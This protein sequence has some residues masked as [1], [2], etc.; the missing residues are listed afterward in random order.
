M[1]GRMEH[2]ACRRELRKYVKFPCL[3]IGIGGGFFW[4]KKV[5]EG[6]VGV[7]IRPKLPRTIKCDVLEGLPFEDAS[8]NCVV[9]TEIFEHIEPRKR[10]FLVCEI[11]RVLKE[12]GRIIISVPKRHRV[13]FRAKPKPTRDSQPYPHVL[14]PE[15]LF[16]DEE[17]LDFVELFGGN[18]K[19]FRISNKFYE[20]FGAVIFL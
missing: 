3:D 11:L 15:W 16:D 10:R 19:V 2:I 5:P 7:D 14:Y 4:D 12:R 20:G 17:F 8:F 18:A 9:A 13:N 6:V 1:V